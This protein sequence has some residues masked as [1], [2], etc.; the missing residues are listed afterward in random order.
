MVGVSAWSRATAVLTPTTISFKLPPSTLDRRYLH[1]LPGGGQK[2][3]NTSHTLPRPSSQ[4]GSEN[5]C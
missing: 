2:I 4:L 5:S 3:E 1:S